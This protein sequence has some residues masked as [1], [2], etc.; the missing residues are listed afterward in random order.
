MAI[1]SRGSEKVLFCNI[2]KTSGHEFYPPRKT[3]KYQSL[4]NSHSVYSKGIHG[5]KNPWITQSI[6][7]LHTLYFM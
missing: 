6:F 3:F 1:V 4:Q 7:G 2:L 5:V